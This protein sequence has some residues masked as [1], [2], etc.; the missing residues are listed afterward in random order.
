LVPPPPPPPPT[1]VCPN[2]EGVQEEVPAGYHLDA[3]GNCVEDEEPPTDVC[4]NLPG[5]QTGMPHGYEL[6][7]EG[8]CV[9]RWIPP[10]VVRCYIAGFPGLTQYYWGDGYW[11]VT[12]NSEGNIVVLYG[13]DDE[14]R[15]PEGYYYLF[16]ENEVAIGQFYFDGND[17]TECVLVPSA[18]PEEPPVAG[19]MDPLTVAAALSALAS[20]AAYLGFSR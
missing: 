1:D 4:P 12:S 17:G 5:L 6:D 3:E 18:P 10:E 14:G 20:V 7:A 16:D 2:L 11:P 9:E 13:A 15:G 19:A 8:N